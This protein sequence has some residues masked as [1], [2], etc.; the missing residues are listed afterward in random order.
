IPRL[1][2]ADGVDKGALLTGVQTGAVPPPLPSTSTTGTSTT[3]PSLWDPS[4][5]P[6]EF[7]E[8]EINMVGDITR[9]AAA[10]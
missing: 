6:L 5:N 3:A 4:F 1:A 10:S 7:I 9:F 8:R 2:G